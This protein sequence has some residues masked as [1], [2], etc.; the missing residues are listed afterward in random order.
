MRVVGTSVHLFEIVWRESVQPMMLV[1]RDGE[2]ARGPAGDSLFLHL[3]HLS[4]ERCDILIGI[5]FLSLERII[6]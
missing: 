4:A 3:P 1:N 6:L 2:G 5:P